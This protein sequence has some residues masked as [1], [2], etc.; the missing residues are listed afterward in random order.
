M[1]AV[2]VVEALDVA[3]DAGLGRLSGWIAFMMYQFGLELGKEALH[4]GIVVAVARAAHA[5][6]DALGNGASVCIA[7]APSAKHVG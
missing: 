5:D 4:R 7:Q 2:R 6:L 3:K 1:Q